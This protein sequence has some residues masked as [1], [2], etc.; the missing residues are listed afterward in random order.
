MFHFYSREPNTY[1]LHYN[2]RNR[3]EQ[4]AKCLT[5]TTEASLVTD[6]SHRRID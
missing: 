3:R 5:K 2:G 1:R 4:E 6:Q